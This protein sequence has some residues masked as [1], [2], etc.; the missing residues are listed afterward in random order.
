MGAVTQQVE[1]RTLG[2]DEPGFADVVRLVDDYRVHYGA[3]RTGTGPSGGS[4]ARPAARN[5]AATSASTPAGDAVGVA[6]VFPA[7]MTV[8]LDELWALR[9]LYVASRAPRAGS[10]TRPGRPGAGRRP[11]RRRAADRPADGDGQ[12]CG[13]GLSTGASASSRPRASSHCPWRC[14]VAADRATHG[15]RLATGPL[16]VAALTTGVLL[17]LSS[18]YGPHRDELYFVAAGHHPQWGYPDQPPLTPL[19][20]AAA[21]SVAPGSMLALRALSAR[22]GG[23]RRAADRRPRA[24]LGGDRG[25]QLLAAVV[26]GTGAG[27]LA[28]GHLLSTATPDLLVWTVVVRL[29]VATLQHD[30]PRLWLAVGLTLGGGA[31]EQEPGRLPRRR[32]RRRHRGHASDP[33]PP[34]LA[35][36]L[37]RGSRRR[38]PVAAQ[39]RL[40][41]PARLAAARAGR[42][43]PRRVPHAR[44]HVELVGFQV[45]MLNPLG[46]LLAAIG[47][48]GAWRRPEWAFFRPVPIAYGVLL[49]VFAADRRQELLPARPAAAAGRGRC[50]GGRRPP[51]A[52]RCAP[53]RLPSSPSRRCS[54]CPHCSP[55]CPW[56]TLDSSFYPA[57]N[58]DGLET[59]GWPSVVDTVRGVLDDLPP[60]DRRTA[61]V[62][63]QNYGQAGALLRYGVDA[64]VFSGHNGF[65]DWGPPTSDGPVVYVGRRRPAGQ[66]PADRLPAGRDAADGRRQ[67][68][69]RA[70]ASGSAPARPARGRRPGPRSGTWTP[71]RPRVPGRQTK[72]A[73]GRVVSPRSSTSARKRRPGRRRP[74]VRASG[75]RQRAAM[76]DHGAAAASTSRAGKAARAASAIGSTTRSSA[77]SLE[78]CAPRPGRRG[79]PGCGAAS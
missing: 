7:P 35:L 56:P 66:R 65:G 57:L 31:G 74:P 79:R 13:A 10:G 61:V 50:G 28:I 6:L 23:R 11:R 69:G 76:R 68:G 38:R 44:R 59:I 62:V 19:I 63:T 4:G 8:R 22:D 55:C 73:T 26:T 43:H 14:D 51:V 12:R 32:S 29:V 72:T 42:R 71:D 33:A 27:V 58:E 36:G 5:C 34:A 16:V 24:R 39:P 49:V 47:A 70:T 75:G 64:P 15:T 1:V 60:A 52:R 20:A 3:P 54:R 77:S 25:A 40:A 21:D 37:G 78:R 41:G 18:R 46:A 30:R 67:R 53:V 17:A 2:V 9:D 48:R 45:L